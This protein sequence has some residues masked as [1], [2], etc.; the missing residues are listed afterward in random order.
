VSPLAARLL[1][2]L[3]WLTGIFRRLSREGRLL[4]TTGCVAAAF[5]ADVGRTES[6]VLLLATAGL[7]LASLLRSWG[8]DLGQ[9]SV[10]ARAPRRVAL[11]EE[12]SISVILRNEG[13]QAREDIRVEASWLPRDGRWITSAQTVHS[14]PPGGREIAVLRARFRQRG[15]H[16][17]GGIR[18]AA[19]VPLGLAQGAAVRTDTLRVVVVPRLARVVRVTTPR[20]QRSQSGGSA[21]AARHGDA[22]E[23]LGVRPYRPGDAVRDLHARSWARVGFPVVR[24]YQQEYF[25]RVG[26]VVDIDG[27]AASPAHLEAVLSL[28]AGVVAALCRGESLVDALVIDGR[29]HPLGPGGGSAIVDESLDLLAA[30]RAGPRFSTARTM[31]ALGP[32]LDRLSAVVLVALAWDDERTAVARA[33]RAQGVGC[34]ALV[35]G[36][37]GETSMDKITV[38]VGSITRGEEL[39]L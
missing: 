28:A 5:S 8:Q 13:G 30:V 24:E 35:V 11:G 37:K 15:E 31:A 20:S 25:T 12:L 18:A 19:L 33:I 6:H 34:A 32:R 9:V 1:G 16:L 27:E 22:T 7:L 3:G 39:S 38:P 36:E 23:L 26:V 21:Q 14:L 17:I 29:A 10:E 2:S 4:A